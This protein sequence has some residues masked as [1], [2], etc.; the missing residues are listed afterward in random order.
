MSAKPKEQ[1]RR[2][3]PETQ[4]GVLRPA[5][6]GQYIGMTERWVRGAAQAGTIPFIRVGKRAIRFRTKDLDAWLDSRANLPM[7][8]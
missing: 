6:A 5:E 4:G 3:P 8:Q 2:E 1:S 7:G